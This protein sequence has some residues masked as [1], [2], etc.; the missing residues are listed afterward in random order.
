M[1]SA[2]ERGARQKFINFCSM[3]D[4]VSLVFVVTNGVWYRITLNSLVVFLN[5]GAGKECS[6][7]VSRMVGMPE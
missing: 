4:A 6:A 5:T 1:I 7:I 2:R 3:L